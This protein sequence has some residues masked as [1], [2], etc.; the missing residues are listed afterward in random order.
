MFKISTK[1]SSCYRNNE[2]HYVIKKPNGLPCC[3]HASC[4]ATRELGHT[5]YCL[6]V[7]NFKYFLFLCNGLGVDIVFCLQECGPSSIVE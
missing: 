1:C 5:M 7:V 2:R 3:H 4:M 6:L